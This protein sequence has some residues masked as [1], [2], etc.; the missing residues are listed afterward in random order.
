MNHDKVDIMDVFTFYY[1][2]GIYESF[3]LKLSK[4]KI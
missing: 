1:A 2:P 3:S 4:T